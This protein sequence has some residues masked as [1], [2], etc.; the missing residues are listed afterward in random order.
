MFA[1]GKKILV[2]VTG[3]IA[4]YK[5]AFLVREL[6]KHGAQVRV[7]MTEAATQFVAPLTF[8][9]LAESVVAV[10]LFS[11]THSVATAHIEWARWPDLIVICPASANTIAKIAHGFADNMLTT[12]VLASKAPL[13]IC[14]AM[15][16]EMYKNPLYRQNEDTLRHAGHTI[17][18]PGEGELACGEMGVGRLADP[19]DILDAVAYALTPH[20]LTGKKIVVTAGPTREALDPVRFLSNRSSGKM[21]YAVA[22]CAARR[23]AEVT[24]VSGPSHLRPSRRVKFKAIETVKQ[25]AESVEESLPDADV[26]IMAA[27]PADFKPVA[28]APQKIKKSASLELQLEKTPDI[29]KNAGQI[30]GERLLVGFALETEHG[31]ENARRKLIE[32]NC[33]LMVLNNALI[34]GAGFEVETNQVTLL[35]ADGDMKELPMMS[36]SQTAQHILDAVESLLALKSKP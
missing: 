33:D 30:K 24:L 34:P 27:A 23:G 13:L 35:F 5:A 3:G 25:M 15:N 14:P 12:T 8:E 21:G 6:K 32:K 26:L 31:I 22:E 28:A 9:T 36:K 4:A 16:V 7:M 2:G 29:L 18:T 17:V 11:G 1:Q 20:T 19:D 10:D